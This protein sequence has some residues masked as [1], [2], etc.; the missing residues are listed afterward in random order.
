MSTKEFIMTATERDA[1]ARELRGVRDAEAMS[2]IIVCRGCGERLG[3]RP[4]S[5]DECGY[6]DG[7][8][9]WY[10]D[11]CRKEACKTCL[12]ENYLEGDRPC[13]GC[14]YADL[15]ERGNRDPFLSPKEN[16]VPAPWYR[17]EPWDSAI[18]ALILIAA[19]F[20]AYCLYWLAF[21][22]NFT[23]A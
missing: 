15:A 21:I 5:L 13:E 2:L 8:E 6:D 7:D 20:G 11:E 12:A 1:L 16:L 14:K 9:P 19:G 10:C 17:R 22:F 3:T 18:L 23:Q 4:I